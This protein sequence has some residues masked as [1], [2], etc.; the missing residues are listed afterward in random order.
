MSRAKADIKLGTE[1]RWQCQTCGNHAFVRTLSFG[2]VNEYETVRHEKTVDLC[3]WC[4]DLLKAA[5]K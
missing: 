4:V 3:L 5:L 2:W 1:P